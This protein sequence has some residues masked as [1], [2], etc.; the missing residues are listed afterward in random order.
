M[1]RLYVTSNSKRL[2]QDYTYQICLGNISILDEVCRIRHYSG[3]VVKESATYAGSPGFESW[4]RCYHSHL[5][6]ETT[7]LHELGSRSLQEKRRNVNWLPQQK[8]GN[9]DNL[10]FLWL[11][12]LDGW[13]HFKQQ[14]TICKICS[15]NNMLSE[16]SRMSLT[17]GTI[18]SCFKFC[19]FIGN[20]VEPTEAPTSCLACTIVVFLRKIFVHLT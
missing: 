19:I 18:K 17:Q 7:S 13:C 5:I 1:L 2:N 14:F 10:R 16:K 12:P 6:V 8:F 3:L 4:R 11:I 15:W 9:V 20:D